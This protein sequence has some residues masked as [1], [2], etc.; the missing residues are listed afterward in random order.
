MTKSISKLRA[1]LGAAWATPVGRT[2]IQA[3]LAI[4][5]ASGTGFTSVAV[6]KTAVIAAGAALFAALQA[7]ARG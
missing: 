2:A 4:V 1:L 7:E 5:V 3:G 6:W